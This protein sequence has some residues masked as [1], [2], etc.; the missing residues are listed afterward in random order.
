MVDKIIEALSAA[1]FSVPGMVCEGCAERV[2]NALLAVP[3][4]REVKPSAW[5][6]R[7]KVLFE[8]TRVE[9]G[10]LTAALTAIGFEASEVTKR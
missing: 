3:G 10:R 9:V 8:P 7:I 4:V 6:K 1:E 2:C 5:R